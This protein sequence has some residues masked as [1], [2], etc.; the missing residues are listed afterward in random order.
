MGEK[1]EGG[2][3]SAIGLASGK[4][5]EFSGAVSGASLRVERRDDEKAEGL[6]KAAYAVEQI[7]VEWCAGEG[8]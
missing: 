6:W 7:S 4:K 5:T 2:G 3:T 8:G 1:D